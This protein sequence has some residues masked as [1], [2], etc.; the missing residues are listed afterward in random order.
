MNSLGSRD[1]EDEKWGGYSFLTY[2]EVAKLTDDFGS[3]LIGLGLKP[4]DTLGNY[5]DF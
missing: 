1:F 2:E 5:N 4:G 3:G